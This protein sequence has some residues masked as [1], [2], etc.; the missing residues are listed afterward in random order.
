[1]NRFMGGTI[2]LTGVIF[3]TFVFATMASSVFAQE[4][5]TP[6]GLDLQPST[7][8][9]EPTPYLQVPM[10]VQP[11]PVSTVGVSLNLEMQEPVDMCLVEAQRECVIEY[12]AKNNTVRFPHGFEVSIKRPEPPGRS[13]FQEPL[14]ASPAKTD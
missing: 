4:A 1:L 8:I 6:Q 5:V 11:L 2:R 3:T 9:F 13:P 7:T 12:I 10:R 14:A